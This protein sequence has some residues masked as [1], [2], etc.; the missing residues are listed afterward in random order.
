VYYISPQLWA[1][2]PGRINTMRRFV[3]EVLVIFPF[4]SAIYERAGIPVAFVGHPLV[5]LLA[6]PVAR[7]TF[8]GRIGLASGA[9][10]VGLLPGSRRNEVRATWPV[11][12]SAAHHLQ[13]QRPNIQFVVAQAPGLPDALFDTPSASG[14]RLARVR[15][16]TDAVISVSDVVV[17]ASGTATVQTALHGIPMVIV[18]RLSPLTYKLGRPFVKVDTF[19]M[20]NLIAGRRI[21]PELIQGDFTPATVVHEVDRYLADT[22]YADDVRRSL[23]EVRVALGGP[24]ASARAASQILDIARNNGRLHGQ[25]V[26]A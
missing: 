8:L 2:R 4:E 13:Q 18:Y 15:G 10:T 9:P 20:V 1:W 5:E 12:I 25:E 6:A 11:L 7:D 21:V 23:A 17:T 26:L 24:G 3:R 19:G 22:A 14:L 16:D